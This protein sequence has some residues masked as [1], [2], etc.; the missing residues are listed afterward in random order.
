[1]YACLPRGPTVDPFLLGSRLTKAQKVVVVGG[2]VSSSELLHEILPVAQRPVFGSL[3]GAPIPAFGLIP[4]THPHVVVKEEIVRLDPETGDV[5]FADGSV[6]GDVDHVVFG[7][8]YTFSLPFLPER[9]ARIGREYRRLPGVWQ[10]TWDIEDPS[11]T[12]VGMVSVAVPQYSSSITAQLTQRIQLGGGFT[13]RVYEYQ[14]VAV[15]R[16]L[17]GRASPLPPAE[18]QRDWER[19]R[20]AELGGG[21]N[22]YSIAPDYGA[23]FELLRQIAREP[24]PGTTGR[25]L[26]PFDKRLLD[27]WAGMVRPKIEAWE[28]TRKRAEEELQVEKGGQVKARL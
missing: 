17:C 19:K 20:V 13:F 1:M 3:R 12:F 14:A 10:H 16:F 5:H 23:F 7:T 26:A 21:K 11:L 15:A 27:V 22:Y 6:L 2:S 4:W 25:V 24:T 28:R 9:Q 8:G 18:E